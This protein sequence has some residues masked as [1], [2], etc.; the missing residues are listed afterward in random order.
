M[1]V[2]LMAEIIYLARLVPREAVWNNSIR[3]QI[4]IK[5][6]VVKHN[7][8]EPRESKFRSGVIFWYSYISSPKNS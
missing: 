1:V 8:K 3:I 4:T 6:S 5:T 2:N 7:K